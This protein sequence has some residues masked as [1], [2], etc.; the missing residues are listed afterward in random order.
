MLRNRKFATLI[1]GALLGMAAMGL[2]SPAGAQTFSLGTAQRFAVLGA[3]TVTNTGP[4]VIGGDVGVF[5]GTGIFGF[6]PGIVTPP[7]TIHAGDAVAAQAQNDLTTSFNVLAGLAPTQ[8]LSGQ[9]LGGLTLLPGVYNFSSAAQLNGTLT[10]N[11][12]G[13]PDALFVFKIGGTFTTASNSSVALINGG[14][15]CNIFFQVGSGA[16]LGTNTAFKGNILALTSI[17][18]N[19][20]ASI[21]SGR[22]LARNGAVTL[23]TNRISSAGCPIVAGPA[24]TFSR[25]VPNGVVPEPGTLALLGG[26]LGVPG[27]LGTLR[28]FRRRR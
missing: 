28:R 19:T 3:S 15:D 12:Q 7:G 11:A 16:T 18:L 5:P 17:T 10:L 13:D 23:D 25:T 26:G 2:Q 24:G 21:L 20:G 14:N 1:G 9:N 8:N 4:S 22:A 27:C 6:P